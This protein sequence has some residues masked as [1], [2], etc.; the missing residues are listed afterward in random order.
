MSEPKEPD[1]YVQDEGQEYEIGGRYDR[2]TRDRLGRG[3]T[4]HALQPNPGNGKLRV[5]GYERLE[6]N[7]N[8]VIHIR[9]EPA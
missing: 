8:K 1:F 9:F 3:G 5:I 2:H 7:G 4:D 6:D